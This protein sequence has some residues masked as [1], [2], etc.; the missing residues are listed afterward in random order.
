MDYTF[1]LKPFDAFETKTSLNLYYL[2]IF[3]KLI[4]FVHINWSHGWRWKCVKWLEILMHCNTIELCG[5]RH[6]ISKCLTAVCELV[7]MASKR[8]LELVDQHNKTVNV[9]CIKRIQ[10]LINVWTLYT[11]YSPLYIRSRSSEI[12][13][14][15]SSTHEMCH[16]ILAVF[17]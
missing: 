4:I 11:Y 5:V 12:K 1:E 15:G 14:T 2:L 17:I 6:E 16:L 7:W 8:H 3:D 13:L 10:D 9:Y